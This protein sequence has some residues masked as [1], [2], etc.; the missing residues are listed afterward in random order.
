MLA[1]ELALVLA[2]M[3]GVVLAVTALA[4]GNGVS[5]RFFV[6]DKVS[7]QVLTLTTCLPSCYISFFN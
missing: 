4:N 2:V 1:V 5:F 3:L 7:H 6:T